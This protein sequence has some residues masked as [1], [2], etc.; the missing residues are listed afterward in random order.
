MT[1]G[2][3]RRQALEHLSQG[4]TT[5]LDFTNIER[6]VEQIATY[7]QAHPL[8]AVLATDEAT[9]V[10]A[11]AAAAA[12]DLRCNPPE[13][14]RDCINKYRLRCRLADAGLPCPGFRRVGRDE[15]AALLAPEID[16][17][18][19]LKPLSL[20]ASRGVIRADD[21]A[22]F[23][24][25]FQRIG[26][27]LDDPATTTPRE[28]RRYILVEDY[29]PGV[30][31]A[32]EALLDDGELQLLALFDKPDPLVGPFFEETLYITPS[33]LAR[34]VQ[35]AI[36]AAVAQAVSAL[37]LCDGPIHAELRLGPRGPVVIELAPRSIGGLCGRTLRFGVGM[38]LEELIVRHA[39]RLPIESL[40][41]ERSPAGV[42]MLPIPRAGRLRAVE[43]LER[44]RSL[45]GIED[46][47]ITIH[48]GQ[49]VV[50][51]PEGHR[52][53]GFAFARAETAA[54]V[55]TAL[56]NANAALRFDIGE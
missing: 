52:Y 54:A 33:R 29:V 7:A 37:G 32:L 16:Y 41:R 36:L 25:A 13:A 11:A 10:L 24:S 30:E 15:D 5:R 12:L 8:R 19:V 28:T 20:S 31:V 27:L 48:L 26:R 51:L 14:V 42:M 56:R 1:V 39:L 2:S 34:A 40:G 50:P 38:S 17:P 23:V 47:T 22:G 6:G 45:P 44:A 3:N 9:T 18:C 55:E 4:G 21:E 43:G 35:D 49:P 46:I 53:L